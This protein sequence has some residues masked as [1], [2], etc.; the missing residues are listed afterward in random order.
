VEA[1]DRWLAMDGE[2]GFVEFEVAVDEGVKQLGIVP[3]DLPPKPLIIRRIIPGSWAEK[4]GIHPG[5]EFYKVNDKKT[6]D[7]FVKELDD[8]MGRRRPLQL[9]FRRPVQVQA[10]A[11]AA[12]TVR[13]RPREEPAP[14][15]G[16][17]PAS[18]CASAPATVAAPLREEL[19]RDLVGTWVYDPPDHEYRI[20]RLESGQL[21]FLERREVKQTQKTKRVA[22]VLF[23]RNEWLQGQLSDVKRRGEPMGYIRLRHDPATDTVISNVRLPDEQGWGNE[24]TVAYRKPGPDMPLEEDDDDL[25]ST[26]AQRSVLT[27]EVQQLTR[28]RDPKVGGPLP[29]VNRASPQFINGK[30]IWPEQW[31]IT[32]AQCQKLLSKLRKDPKWDSSNSIYKLVSDFLVPW[33]RGTG[34]GYALTENHSNPKEVNVMVSHAWSEN[35]EELLETLGRSTTS[36]D[37]LF[38]AALSLYH[39]ED[40]S[41]PSLRQ[42]L[43]KEPEES[44]FYRVLQCIHRNCQHSNLW[45]WRGSIQMAPGLVA[46]IGLSFLYVPVIMY[47]CVPSLDGRQCAL[48]RVSGARGEDAPE[49]TVNWI[50]SER[51]EEDGAPFWGGFSD[52]GP[53]WC[54]T[55][56]LA[57]LF[58]VAP[59]VLWCCTRNKAYNGRLLAV[60]G[61]KYGLFSRL[62]CVHEVYTARTLKVPVK[63]GNTLAYPGRCR[64]QQA[65]CLQDSD[66]RAIRRAMTANGEDGYQRVDRALRW[67]VC[68]HRWWLF[69]HFFRWALVLT[70]LRSADLRLLSASAITMESLQG[71][72]WFYTAILGVLSGVVLSGLV[73]FL[74]AFMGRGA[75]K[76]LDLLAGSVVL[77]ATSTAVMAV[78]MYYEDIRREWPANMRDVLGFFVQGCFGYLRLG[79]DEHG[80]TL[81]TRYWGALSQTLGLGG[82][83]LMALMPFVCICERPGVVGRAPQFVVPALGVA[84]ALLYTEIE[85]PDGERSPDHFFGEIIF[86][87]T[88]FLSR[89]AVPFLAMWAGASQFGLRAGSCRCRTHRSQQSVHGARPE[90][91]ASDAAGVGELDEQ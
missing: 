36:R 45:R 44:P 85:M 18:A 13:S 63:F 23:H 64:T 46:I 27:P 77:L 20:I 80:C 31:G 60:P 24:D 7:I 17:S 35:A 78:C 47:G 5:D 72:Q 68:G 76:L 16:P 90:T 70:L 57:A 82:C 39:A 38:I 1:L 73:V 2:A 59:L 71:F 3:G 8:I 83:Y 6:A 15:D 75:P 12:A 87:L 84:V 21:Q 91:A 48:R 79:S 10:A 53:Y 19:F 37:V 43:G 74:M 32:R 50:W 9:S 62:W 86:W 88:A 30:P 34:V 61:F 54:W 56:V 28:P 40:G 65:T 67:T 41:G 29:D 22:G 4:N 66:D 69:F 51:Y 42:Q 25:D 14:V 11:P 55:H 49:F 58:L 89:S 26:L 81:L 52:T 33:T